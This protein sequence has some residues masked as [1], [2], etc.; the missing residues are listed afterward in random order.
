[1]MIKCRKT[2]IGIFL[3]L[4]LILYIPVH[5][6]YKKT[7]HQEVILETF[8]IKNGWGYRILVNNKTLI[9]QPTIPAIDTLRSFPNETSAYAVGSL[10]L[11]RLNKNQ[12]FSVSL[13]DIQHSLSD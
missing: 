8:Q 7:N 3:L 6:V 1:M 9:Y 5:K 11:E 4:I 10:V 13:Y 2:Y 12:D